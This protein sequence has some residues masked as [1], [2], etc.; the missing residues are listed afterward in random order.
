MSDDTPAA[1]DLGLRPRT[2]GAGDPR[3]EDST[4]VGEADVDADRLR[5]GDDGGFT[6]P[7]GGLGG[8]LLG[9]DDESQEEQ[10]RDDG[11]PVGEAD[12]DADVERSR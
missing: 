8:P 1:S 7:G 3:D 5:T 12:R 9:M 2:G 11:Q 10:P 6:G 4:T